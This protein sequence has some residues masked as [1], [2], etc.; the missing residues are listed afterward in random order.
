MN[1]III[2][3]ILI[4]L[5]IIVGSN[6]FLTMTVVIFSQPTVALPIGVWLTIAIG[7]GLLSSSLIQLTIF[8]D[9]RILQRQLR[10]L[11]SRTQQPDEDIF[12]Y[13]SS[14][15]EADNST[16]D[17]S[18]TPPKTSRFKSYRSKL[19]DRF[20][21]EP[22]NQSTPVDDRDDW[23]AE[24]AANRQL[25][26]ED[27]PLPSRQQDRSS[28]TDRSTIG[29]DFPPQRHN[30]YIYPDP[31]A[32]K[33]DSASPTSREVYDADFR[34]IQPPYKQPPATEFDD[35]DES[36]GREDTDT[37]QAEDDARST[38][39]VKPISPPRPTPS[40]NLD[41]EDWGFDF[42]SQDAPVRRK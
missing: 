10:Q 13:T 24:P 9:R 20:T 30:Q 37:N 41:D 6:L 12:T 39:Y 38:A 40:N 34:L 5:G 23:G 2:F 29:N 36:F 11:Q 18:T 26:W 32:A 16:P 7:A 25:D 31:P 33:I 8:I 14:P 1:I 27:A 17:K 42:D 3:A 4:L 15:P 21:N 22:S 28:A 35:N 19:T